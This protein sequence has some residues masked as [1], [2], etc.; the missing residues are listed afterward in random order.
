MHFSTINV[1]VVVV[2]AYVSQLLKHFL[3]VLNVE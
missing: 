1:V 2:F 3:I